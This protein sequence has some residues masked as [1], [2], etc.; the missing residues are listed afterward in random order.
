MTFYS[1][2][3]GI[4]IILCNIPH[5]TVSQ[6]LYIKLISAFDVSF[7]LFSI[8]IASK[9][10]I[11]E[12]YVKKVGHFEGEYDTVKKQSQ[13]INHCA[14]IHIEALELMNKCSNIYVVIAL[15]QTL[16]AVGQ[17]VLTFLHILTVFSE[18]SFQQN[19]V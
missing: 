10:T 3:E 11:V 4:F 17:L 5:L 15:L 1:C 18:I 16:A 12:F 7:V 9:L 13:L 14:K 6:I 2:F 19:F 8:Y